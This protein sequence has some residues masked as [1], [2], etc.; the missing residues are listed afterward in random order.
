VASIGLQSG[1]NTITVTAT[2]SNSVT[3]TDS[4]AV[5][6]SNGTPVVGTF[7]VAPTGDDTRT[8]TQ[9]QVI[10]TPFQTLQIALTCALG[11]STIYMRAGTYSVAIDT[12]STPIPSGSAATPTTIASYT[13]ET[14]TL[15][16]PVGKVGV[17]L[18][19]ASAGESYIVLDRLVLDGMNRVNCNALVVWDPSHHI[20]FQNG[21]MKNTYW[22]VAYSFGAANVSILT[23]TIHD[24]SN[25]PCVAL[26]V[27]ST[28]G[29][30][31]G[32]TLYNCAGA[33][34]Q[35]DQN[36]SPSGTQSGNRILANQVRAAGATMSQAGI[37][38]SGSTGQ[39]INNL[40]WGSYAGI[41]ITTGASGAKVYNNTVYGNTTSGITVNSGAV[42][43]NL[44]NNITSNNGTSQLVN[45]GTSTV[46]NTNLQT[47]PGTG[48]FVNPGTGATADFHLQ[49]TATV[50][51]DQGT[52]LTTDV[53]TDYE[54]VSR[55]QGSGY[56]IGASEFAGT[57][58]PPPGELRLVNPWQSAPAFR[59]R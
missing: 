33:G 37:T 23:S 28:N 56:D 14:A 41:T 58:P 38:F 6:L 29:T 26:A 12:S 34:V 40:V 22:E 45:N 9:A 53:P 13:G 11:G 55:P 32:N 43:T 3:A 5:T 48:F 21:E 19:H 59:R 57:P 8:C 16:L 24:T 49:N 51:I 7:Y 17:F 15:Q 25:A 35:A 50:A 20:T 4:I 54:N 18:F 10:G 2:D 42:S 31:Q 46:Q 36:V 27:S 47:V 52:A 1:L 30:V 39:V 44:T